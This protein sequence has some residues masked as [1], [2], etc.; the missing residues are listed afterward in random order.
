MKKMH[1]GRFQEILQALHYLDTYTGS[2]NLTSVSTLT[3]LACA[4]FFAHSGISPPG[5]GFFCG[6]GF[7]CGFCLPSAML[8][9]RKSLSAEISFPAAGASLGSLLDV[10]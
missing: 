1:S 7:F 9:P 6:V 5:F 3:F 10:N 8:M 4:N 2:V